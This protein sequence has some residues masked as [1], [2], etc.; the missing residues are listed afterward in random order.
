MVPPSTLRKNP[1][2]GYNAH[3]PPPLVAEGFRAGNS[4]THIESQQ[5]TKVFTIQYFVVG[6]LMATAGVLGCLLKAKITGVKAAKCK[7]GTAIITK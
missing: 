5:P 2:G 3:Y 4:T 6:G 1:L 7:D